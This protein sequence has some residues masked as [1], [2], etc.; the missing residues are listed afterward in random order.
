[1]TTAE[2][3]KRAA[4]VIGLALIPALIWFLFDVV[5]VMVGGVLIAVLLQL[6]A[7]PFLRLRLPRSIALVCSG[8]IIIAILGGA[9]YLFGAGVAS[10][11]QEVLRRAD[12][13]RQSITDSLHKSQLGSLLLSH[14]KS[15]NVPV[16]E[17][18][19]RVFGVSATFIA[20]VVVTVFAGIY[21][22]AQPALYR[23]GLSKL[24]PP[25][26]RANANETIDLVADG[27]RL[28]LLGQLIQ[29]T[30][31]GVLSGFAVWMIGLPSPFAL[32][33]IAGVTEFVPYLGP[34]VASI[35]AILVAITTNPSAILWTIAAYVIIHQAEGQLVMPMIQ[36]KMVFIPPAVML[37]SIVT[38]SSLFGLA[39]AI[40]AAPI[41][42]LL[43]VLIN[44]LYVRDSLGEEA[45]LPGE[46]AD[47][48]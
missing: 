42:V 36:Q 17:I 44:K 48:A 34:I 3:S 30:I 47:D 38:I 28:W 45:Y 32:G 20:A 4:I 14:M 24:A 21:L 12:E 11:M 18:I 6:G 19:S 16:T 27:L 5:L 8:L 31:I 29:M 15:N 37:L 40:F 25:S 46:T 23:D 9:G 35:P 1:M 7:E 10:E 22:T 2:F 41:T 26:W 33:V 43:F 13:A 39:G